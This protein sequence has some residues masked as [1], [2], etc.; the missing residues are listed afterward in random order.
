LKRARILI[1]AGVLLT[2]VAAIYAARII[3]SQ[4]SCA[5]DGGMWLAASNRCVC[6]YSQQGTYADVP[7]TD[8]VA[9]R[10]ACALKTKPDD[11]TEE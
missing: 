10:A 6:S 8:Q 7:T 1:F 11:W 5:D 2:V 3:G 9:H 4:D